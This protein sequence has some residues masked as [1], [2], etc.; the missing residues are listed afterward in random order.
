MSLKIDNQY[1]RDSTIKRSASRDHY[2]LVLHCH[3][4]K[5]RIFVIFVSIWV[6]FFSFSIDAVS[7]AQRNFI[8][9]STEACSMVN[10][11]VSRLHGTKRAI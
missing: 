3:Q 4:D 11:V 1:Q 10:G 9:V 2:F 7:A 6:F 8:H 5:N